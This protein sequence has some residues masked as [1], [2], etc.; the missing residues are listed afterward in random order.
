MA[1]KS[2]KK[3]TRSQKSSGKTNKSTNKHPTSWEQEV[4]ADTPYDESIESPRSGQ[5]PSMY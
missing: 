4:S 5:K 1:H 3:N 2:N